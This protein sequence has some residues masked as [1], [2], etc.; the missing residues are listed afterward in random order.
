MVYLGRGVGIFRL[1]L[2]PAFLV[3]VPVFGDNSRRGERHMSV[4]LSDIV[5]KAATR[6]R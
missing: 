5:S 2:L 6:A 3:S 4:V 1:V